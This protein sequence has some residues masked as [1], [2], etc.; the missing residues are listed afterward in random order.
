[1]NKLIND[2]SVF[3]NHIESSYSFDFD[4]LKEFVNCEINAIK[5]MVEVDEYKI[6]LLKNILY[7]RSLKNILILNSKDLQMLENLEERYKKIIY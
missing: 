5:Q 2:Y 7:L 1:M 4:N 6:I 3:L